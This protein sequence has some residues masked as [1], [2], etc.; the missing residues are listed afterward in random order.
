MT[1]LYLA[2]RCLC[3]AA[4]GSPQVGGEIKKP[5]EASEFT[6]Q[7]DETYRVRVRS[8]PITLKSRIEE[9]EL[10][11]SRGSTRWVEAERLADNSIVRVWHDLTDVGNV[12]PRDFKIVSRDRSTIAV[13]CTRGEG[14]YFREFDLDKV[15]RSFTIPQGEIDVLLKFSL[16]KAGPRPYWPHTNAGEMVL[17]PQEHTGPHWFYP[18]RLIRHRYPTRYFTWG[19]IHHPRRIRHLAW[20]DGVWR[21]EVSLPQCDF[22][23]TRPPNGENWTLKGPVAGK[24]LP[25]PIDVLRWPDRVRRMM[26]GPLLAPQQEAGNGNERTD[27]GR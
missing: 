17:R 24:Q 27:S 14:V 10:I 15:N 2:V 23:F 7:V 26:N 19:L 25:D 8:R 5:P 13:A 6:L 21:L 11:P 4:F 1:V 16:Q 18:L 12:S 9:T 20:K 3:V 22:V